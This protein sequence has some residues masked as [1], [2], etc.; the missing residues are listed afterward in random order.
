VRTAVWKHSSARRKEQ[1]RAKWNGALRWFA[2]DRLRLA[3]SR[4]ARTLF[5]NERV[6]EDHHR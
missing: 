4:S 1:E 3:I 2:Q 6:S 5:L